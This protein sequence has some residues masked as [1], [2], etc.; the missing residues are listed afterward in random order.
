M[1]SITISVYTL[2]I[3]IVKLWLIFGL[4]SVIY[5]TYKD[6]ESNNISFQEYIRDILG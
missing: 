2:I 5:G 4:M 3:F 1:V 6:I